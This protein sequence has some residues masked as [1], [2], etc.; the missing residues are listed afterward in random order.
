MKKDITELYCIIDD[1][2]QVYAEYERKKLLPLN[3]KR[4][5]ACK[6]SLSEMLTIMVM[7]HTSYSK[8]FKYFYKSYIEYVYKDDFTKMSYTLFIELY[9][10]GLKMIHGLKKNMANKL[11]DLNEKV[12]L[13]KRSIIET[14][15]D[16]LKNKFQIEHSRHR[17]PL[18]AFIHIISTLVTYQFMPTKPFIS[19]TYF[20]P[21]P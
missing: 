16:Y 11:L 2:C 6:M 5:R 18:N 20:L 15:F 9:N 3:K 8:N 10:R 4:N 21:N 13:R 14:V 17:S 7:F 1:F 12:L 19:N